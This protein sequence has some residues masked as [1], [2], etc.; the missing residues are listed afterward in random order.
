MGGQGCSEPLEVPAAVS[1][2]ECQV[3]KIHKTRINFGGVAA[4]DLA[5][6][7]PASVIGPDLVARRLGRF[8]RAAAVTFAAGG[9]VRDASTAAQRGERIVRRPAGAGS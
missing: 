3:I 5:G 1:E 9:R 8:D 6:G 4:G 2:D 7:R